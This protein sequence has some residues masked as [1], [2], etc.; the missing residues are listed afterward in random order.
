MEH[1]PFANFAAV[2]VWLCLGAPVFADTTAAPSTATP[3]APPTAGA[4]VAASSQVCMT[5]L[6]SFDSQTQ[7]D[8]YWLG[9]SGYGYGYPMMGTGMGYG[10]GTG[11]TGQDAG[12]ATGAGYQNARPDYDTRTLIAAASILARGGQQQSCEDV[13]TAARASY[14]MYVSDMKN[15][16]SAV[17][18]LPGW[19]QQQLSAAK[20]VTDQT[21]SFRSDQLLGT[22]V[23]TP[24]DEA[25][26]SVDDI[27]MSPQTGKIAYLVIARGGLF[28]FDKSYVPVPWADF[29]VTPASTLLVLDTTKAVMKAAPMVSQDKFAVP[30]QFDQESQ[31][32]DAYWKAK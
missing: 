22:E 29:K 12:A 17:A 21:S 10:Y 8:G 15:G 20:P 1:P 23:R 9:G 14:K 32:V 13:L 4:A 18:D 26:G 24:Q 25:L 11:L 27:V 2:G 5:D 30:G 6:Q 3:A 19:R 31:K 16:N 7:K 28:G